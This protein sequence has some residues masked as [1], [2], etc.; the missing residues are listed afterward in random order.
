MLS[1]VFVLASTHNYGHRTVHTDTTGLQLAVCQ[2][3]FQGNSGTQQ[4][5]PKT[6]P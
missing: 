2:V 4:A 6:R 3:S 5:A 1:Q